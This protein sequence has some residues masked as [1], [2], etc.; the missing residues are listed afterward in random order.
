MVAGSW[1]RAPDLAG[2]IS[3]GE[4]P[5]EALSH[6]QDTLDQWIDE[7]KSLGRAI[8]APSMAAA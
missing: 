3:D 8:P 5:Y 7:A 4:T 2:C 1:R 6:I